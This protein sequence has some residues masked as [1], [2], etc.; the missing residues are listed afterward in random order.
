[1]ARHMPTPTL[2]LQYVRLPHRE[3]GTIMRVALSARVSPT[4]PQREENIDS[5]GAALT[6]YAQQKG[7]AYT[8]SDVYLDRGDSGQ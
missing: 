3:E 5:Q 7:C 4:S 2:R 8:T 1:M 6:E